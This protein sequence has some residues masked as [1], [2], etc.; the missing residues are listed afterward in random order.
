MCMYTH[1]HVGCALWLKVKAFGPIWQRKSAY[2][3]RS[4]VKEPDEKGQRRSKFKVELDE[5]TLIAFG[6][7]GDLRVHYKREL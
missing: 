6:Q 5:V 3:E 2:I 1:T 7:I 4:K